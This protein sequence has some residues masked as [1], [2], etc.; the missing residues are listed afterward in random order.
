MAYLSVFQ[1]S[2]RSIVGHWYI[3]NAAMTLATVSATIPVL[4][5]DDMRC[6]GVPVPCYVAGTDVEMCKSLNFK[7]TLYDSST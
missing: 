4:F 6:Y 7:K 2:D 3:S 5:S 1:L